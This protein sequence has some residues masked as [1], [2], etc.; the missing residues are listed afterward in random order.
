MSLLFAPLGPISEIFYLRDYWHPAY[1][2]NIFGFGIE[3]LLFAF[4]IGG[5]SSVIYEEVFTKKSQK[6]NKENLVSIAIIGLIG[7]ILLI[8]LNIYLKINSIYSSSIVFIF[9]GLIV[10]KRRRDLLKNAFWSGIL[11]ALLMLIF[12]LV[13]LKIFPNIIQDWWKLENI[14]QI[15][16]IGVPIEEIIWGFTWGFLAGP[17]Y[18]FWK[19]KKEEIQ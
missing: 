3:D 11:T 2:I 10:L 17:L 8:L 13:Y 6:T 19:G 5:I 15:L 4:F 7:L 1:V 9:L 12:Y 14:S 18:E 16:V